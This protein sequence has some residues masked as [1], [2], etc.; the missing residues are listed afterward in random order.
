MRFIFLLFTFYFLL[1][2]PVLAIEDIGISR[3]NPASPFYFLKSVRESLE[4][5]LA[6]TTRVKDI[7]RLEF[8]TRRL[9]EAKTLIPINQDLIPPTL[10]RYIAQLNTLTDKHQINDQFVPVLK[11]ALTMHLQVLRRMYDQDTSLRAKMFIRSAMNR[12]IKRADVSNQAKVPVCVFFEKEASSST[13]NQTEQSVLK[14]RAQS[15]IK[16]LNPGIPVGNS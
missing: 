9:R 2:T 7:R 5:Y 4:M 3:I 8:A 1:L 12:V 11:D 13:L 15:C 10:E 6:K 16:S 14:D